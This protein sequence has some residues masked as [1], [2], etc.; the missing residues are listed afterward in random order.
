MFKPKETAIFWLLEC[1]LTKYQAD[2]KP[3][4]INIASL[5]SNILERFALIEHKH[6]VDV[7]LDFC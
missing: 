4:E 1:M 3:V 5:K 6:T 7:Q 2:N